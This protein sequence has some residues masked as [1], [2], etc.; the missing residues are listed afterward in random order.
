MHKGDGSLKLPGARDAQKGYLGF[1]R[2][3]VIFG[4]CNE[5]EIKWAQDLKSWVLREEE[6]QKKNY[7]QRYICTGFEN[8]CLQRYFSVCFFF[9]FLCRFESLSSVFSSQPAKPPLT[10]VVGQVWSQQNLT[11]CLRMS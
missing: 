6:E 10:F 9:F 8:I 3:F 7:K 11:F 4:T 2:G 1:T 5:S